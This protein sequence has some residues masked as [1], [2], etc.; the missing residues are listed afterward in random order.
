MDQN[1]D[2]EIEVPSEAKHVWILVV[3]AYRPM[4]IEEL[5][6]T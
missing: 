6:A 5:L 4:R 1:L 3:G 2:N